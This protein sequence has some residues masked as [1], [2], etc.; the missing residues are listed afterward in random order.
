M[1]KVAK[2]SVTGVDMDSAVLDLLKKVQ[3]KKEEIKKAKTRPSWK[4]NCVFPLPGG[5]VHIQTVS[6]TTKLIELQAYLNQQESAMKQAAEEL[7]VEFDGTLCSGFS[8]DDWREDIKSRANQLL[9]N[10]KE[11]ELKELD[12]RVNKLVSPDQRREMELKALMDILK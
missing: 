7:E 5:V 4:T 3:V 1:A 6:T 10:K 8:F 9:L 11:T 12:E 2:V